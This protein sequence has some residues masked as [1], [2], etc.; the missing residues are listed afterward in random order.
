MCYVFTKSKSTYFSRI[1]GAHAEELDKN[2]IDN[3]LF[4][5]SIREQKRINDKYH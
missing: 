5:S 3:V 1:Q 2:Y 4:K